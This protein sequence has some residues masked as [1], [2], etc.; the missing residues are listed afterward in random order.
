MIQGSLAGADGIEFVWNEWMSY[1]E[2]NNSHWREFLCY[3]LLLGVE[4]NL[5]TVSGL[6]RLQLMDSMMAAIKCPATACPFF[7][8]VVDPMS[9]FCSS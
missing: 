7:I 4:R 3:C 9:V 8:M 2:S 5:V 1:I 6:S